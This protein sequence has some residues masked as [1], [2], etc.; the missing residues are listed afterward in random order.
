MQV[1]SLQK[2]YHSLTLILFQSCISMLVH[3]V[4]LIFIA[5]LPDCKVFELPSLSG[6][7]VSLLDVLA[8]WR[9]QIL[10]SHGTFLR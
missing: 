1:E 9:L 8:P 4:T 7:Q 2:I 6:V 10:I 5:L 3:Q